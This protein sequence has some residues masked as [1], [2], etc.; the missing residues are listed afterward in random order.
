MKSSEVRIAGD[1]SKYVYPTIAFEKYIF[2]L[3]PTIYSLYI[4]FVSTWQKF[5]LNLYINILQKKP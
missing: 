2:D 5:L 3:T 1:R 4:V